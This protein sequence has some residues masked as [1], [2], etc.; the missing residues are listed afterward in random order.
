MAADSKLTL[1]KCIIGP[2]S[3]T[4]YYIKLVSGQTRKILLLGDEHSTKY[5][6][7]AGE[8]NDNNTLPLV[9]Y[10]KHFEM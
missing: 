8:C 1:N 9:R 2:V 3:F 4:F 6:K 7:C 5:T 10:L